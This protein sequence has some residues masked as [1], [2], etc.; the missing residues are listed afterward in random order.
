MVFMEKIDEL[1]TWLLAQR[2]H[3]IALSRS[4]GVSHKSICRIVHNPEHN[5][6]L[7]TYKKLCA[8]ME[9]QR[10]EEARSMF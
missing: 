5:Y 10:A 9:R 1:R 3:W 8:A 7:A 6:E 4:S 2:G